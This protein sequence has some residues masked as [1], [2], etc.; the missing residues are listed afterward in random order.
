VHALWEAKDDIDDLWAKPP[1]PMGRGLMQRV[2]RDQLFPHSGKEGRE[3]GGKEHEN[4][5]GDKLAEL[6][7]ASGLLN[8]VPV[9]AA[10][11]DLCGGPGAWS[12][13]LLERRELRLRGYG[14]TLRSGVGDTG[15]WH[16][17]EKDE[18]Y[19]ELLRRSDWAALWGADG[20]GDL[21]KPG[22]IASCAR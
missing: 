20:T 18:W 2:S 22:N 6:V 16:A 3:A 12:Q 10:F 14:L 13:L 7:S 15:D 1:P 21:L 11:L 4:R 17:Q 9:G 8:D 5:A 19:P